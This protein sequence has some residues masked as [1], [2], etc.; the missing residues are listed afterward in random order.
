MREIHRKGYEFPVWIKEIVKL[1]RSCEY[2][3]EPPCYRP[4][5][6]VD[7]LTGIRLGK[8]IGMNK[9]TIK[10]LANA[11][12]LCTEHNGIKTKEE[13]LYYYLMSER[14]AS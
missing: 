9:E 11:Q 1:R 7:H 3:M 13:N 5:A 2:P 14:L 4:I 10:S 6:I 12:G 8:L